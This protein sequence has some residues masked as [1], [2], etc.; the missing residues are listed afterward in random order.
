MPMLF[1]IAAI[2]LL[3]SAIVMFYAGYL[4]FGFERSGRR[5]P[6]RIK[7]WIWTTVAVALALLGITLTELAK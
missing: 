3:L 4:H 1:W 6:S 7:T 2:P 5:S